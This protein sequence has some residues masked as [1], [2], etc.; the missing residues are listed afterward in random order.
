MAVCA[1]LL[2]V[3][4]MYVYLN[5]ILERSVERLANKKILNAEQRAERAT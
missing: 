4:V 1:L 5:M 3:Y 2:L